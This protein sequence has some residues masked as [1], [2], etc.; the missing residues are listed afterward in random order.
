MNTRT[1]KTFN[2]FISL[3]KTRERLDWS[4]LVNFPRNVI[5][6]EREDQLH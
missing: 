5:S 4:Q 2:L 1:N 6:Q 3:P